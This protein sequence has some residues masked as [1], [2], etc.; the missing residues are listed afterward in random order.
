MKRTKT[1]ENI[2]N[3]NKRMAMSNENSQKNKMEINP[4][5]QIYKHNKKRFFGVA[6]STGSVSSM[7]GSVYQ[8]NAA[9]FYGNKTPPHGTRQFTKANP[10]PS[11]PSLIQKPTTIPVIHI[12]K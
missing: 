7:G 3:F 5:S 11:D 1:K 9:H 8:K 4:Q 6:S 10:F 2:E 12:F